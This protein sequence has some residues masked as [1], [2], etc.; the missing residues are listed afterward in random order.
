MKA[1]ARPLAA[2]GITA[3]GLTLTLR[4]QIPKALPSPE[5]SP[6]AVARLP[7][8]TPAT[9]RPREPLATPTTTG[10]PTATGASA[11]VAAGRVVPTARPTT[12]PRTRP[13][14]QVA[15]AVQTYVCQTYQAGE[16]G[17]VQVEIKVQG[18]HWVDVVHLKLPSG[19]TQTDQIS[20]SAGPELRREALRVQNANIDNISG[21]TYT[22][23]A[24]RQSLQSCIN[25][26]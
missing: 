11:R 9:Q 22:T 1:G 26:W 24:Y 2:L 19:D 21:A 13:T 8:T 14:A 17:P 12:A 23:F 7:A 10:A 4:Y 20:A 16:F 3:L 15:A 18:T 5:P 25:S 6:V